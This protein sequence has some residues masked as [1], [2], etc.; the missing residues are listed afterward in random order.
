MTLG[1]QT[2]AERA[3]SFRHATNEY[4]IGAGTI[5]S[6]YLING[7]VY[8]IT[9]YAQNYVNDTELAIYN[10]FNVDLLPTGMRFPLMTG[11]V[12]D[13]QIVIA[14]E[15]VPGKELW[16]NDDCVCCTHGSDICDKDDC[17]N[18]KRYSILEELGFEDAGCV[19]NV[20]QHVDGTLYLV[21]LP[22]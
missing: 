18:V 14:A 3:Q 19:G 7:V 5:R 21:D 16:V 8:K 15:Y 11:Y 12:V 4:W 13:D 9:S 1:S 17:L 20:V 22:E 2:D 10:S 6:C